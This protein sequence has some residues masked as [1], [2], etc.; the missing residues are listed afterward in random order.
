MVGRQFAEKALDALARRGFARSQVRV[1]TSRRHEI[2]AEFG[3]PSMLR[4]TD[5][6]KLM[7]VGIADDKR[8]TMT[9]NRLSD[10]ALDEAVEALW[11]VTAG[12]HPDPANDIA[13]SQPPQHFTGGPQEPDVERMYQRLS[14]LLDHARSSYPNLVVRQST[15]DFS[16]DTEWLLNSNGVDYALRQGR[17]DALVWFS[18]K[19]GELVSS[20]NGARITR[21]DLDRPLHTC[22]TIDALLRQSTE[23]VHTRKVPQKFTGDLIITPDC[24]DDFLS[25]LLERISDGALIANT[26]LYAGRLGETVAGAGLTLHSKPRDLPAGYF[27]TGDGFEARNACIL[28]RGVLKSYLLGL[29]GARKTGLDRTDSGGCWVVE[30]GDRSLD[31][32]VGEVERGILISR[33]SGGR[34]NDKGDFSGVAK[35]SYYVENGSVQ[36]PVSETM[37]SG[38]LADLL[39]NVAGV[40]RERADFGHMIMPWVRATGVGVS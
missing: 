5:D 2:E 14:E 35:N 24:L 25:F 18:S 7:L 3:R 32:L 11:E 34:P 26:S 21:A 12:S 15:V 22:A 16:E 36:Y 19:E 10:D 31:E 27:V 6:S 1:T 28:E 23:Q 29:Y 13:P 39:Q 38:N 9:V 40:S 8:G 17:Y 33:F 37:I 20:F 30:P 4:T